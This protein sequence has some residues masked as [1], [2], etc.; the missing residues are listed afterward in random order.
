M[1]QHR[2]DGYALDFVDCPE[3]MKYFLMR[4]VNLHRTVGV[5]FNVMVNFTH[6]R[7]INRRSR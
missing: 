1:K 7:R 4:D 2:F 5:L 6:P 3:G